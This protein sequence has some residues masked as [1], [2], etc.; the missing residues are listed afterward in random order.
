M[1][2]SHIDV[3]TSA[4]QQQLAQALAALKS[5]FKLPGQFEQDVLAEVAA[6]IASHRLPDL[7]LTA[8]PFLTIDPPGSMDLDQALFLEKTHQPGSQ[9]GAVGGYLVHYAIADVPSFV[10]PGGALDAETRLRAQTVYTPDGRVP[11]HPA[12][13]SEG[14]A[15]LLPDRV[16]SAFVWE[17]ALND[18]GEA[19][20]TT[21]RRA[22]VRSVARL[23]YEQAQ[24][25]VDGGGRVLAGTTG[26]GDGRLPTGTNDDGAVARTLALLKEIGLKRIALEH[27]RGGASLNVP[28]QE[29]EFDGG[30]YRLVF[31]PALPIEDWNAQISLLTGMAAAALM[32][33][34][35]VGIL[36]TM[37]EPDH[38]SVDRYRRQTIALNKPWPAE[39]P[40][41]DYLRSLDTADPKQLSLMHAATS[42]FRGAG[43]TPFDGTTPERSVQAAVAAPYT[44]TTAPLRRLVDRFVLAICAALSAGESVPQWARDALPQLPAIMMA[45]D[46]Q[47]AKVDRAAID[48]VEAALLSTHIGNEF[49]AVV[50]SGPKTNGNGNAPPSPRSTIQL[51]DPA[52]SAYCEGVLEPGTNIRVR[53]LQA[54]IAVR[55]VLFRQV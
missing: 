36:R 22:A 7:D 43:Y 54:D 39:M 8:R 14:A 42:L 21:V 31:R 18:A 55:A 35:K 5:E 6:S 16:R 20:S 19:V 13:M 46:Q 52:V 30:Q 28:K 50:I 23:D 17:I 32:L 49:D 47:A 26:D 10:P 44:H 45:S 38:G 53:L 11:L 41:G 25:I 34:A 9:P 15:S 37:P 48:T 4:A 29:V 40:Y 33:L 24:A 1:P 12:D 2:Y 51:K 27:Q 3:H